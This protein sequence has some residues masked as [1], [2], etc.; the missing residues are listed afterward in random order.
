M[1]V[2]I[3]GGG[4][5]GMAAA[6]ALRLRGIDIDIYEQAARFEEVGAGVQ[7]SPNGY[8]VLDALGV[9]ADV[10][11]A[12]FEPETI[13]MVQG[14][15][16]KQIVSIPIKQIARKRWGSPYLHLRRS[17]LH[18]ALVA[19]AGA[20]GV[21]THLNTRVEVDQHKSLEA[22]VIIGAD[23]AHSAIRNR[24]FHTS[25]ARFSGMTAWRAVVPTDRL[26]ALPP[27]GATAWAAQNIHAVTTWIDSGNS[28]NF[29]GISE[30]TWQD[31]DW[32]GV[33]DEGEVEEFFAAFAPPVRE[34]ISK[35]ENIRKWALFDHDPLYMLAR[36]NLALI[37]DAA[38][39]M[40]P[41]LAQG[42][43]MALEDA[44][45]LAACIAGDPAQGLATYS[46]NRLPRV[47]RVQKESM[48]SLQRFH[49]HGMVQKTE[50]LGATMID[51]IY[52]SYF[53][54]RLD[55]LYGLDV[56]GA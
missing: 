52:P 8:K 27:M 41:S 28:V 10:E 47:T 54:R 21:V 42:A 49:R 34:V 19:R 17:A 40:M 43:V 26:S 9:A 51:K 33:A 23:G 38:H 18:D 37:G 13:D 53:V 11:A 16:G 44:W 35:A 32:N 3:I 48:F 30:G 46:A 22:D 14:T 31:A 25:P 12:S 29:V 55:W 39:P 7:I 36:D 15:S 1:K 6:I 45:V 5:G 24:L 20:I 2:A 56:T 50:Q 4:I